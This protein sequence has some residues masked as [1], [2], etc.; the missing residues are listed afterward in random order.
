[1][2]PVTRSID[3]ETMSATRI[4]LPWTLF[5]SSAYTGLRKASEKTTQTTVSEVSLTV[6][7]VPTSDEAGIPGLYAAGWFALFAPRGTPKDVVARLNGAMVEALADPAV[8]QRYA[9]LGLDIVAS[10]PDELAAYI[11]A[12]IPKWSA[13]IKASGATLE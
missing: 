2:R 4:V 9:D 12:E 3:A 8:R 13:L 1:M 5:Q 10:T 11:R 6:P 7:N